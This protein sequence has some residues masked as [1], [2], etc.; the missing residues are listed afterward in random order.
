MED[1][2]AA[3]L[4]EKTLSVTTSLCATCK[5]T[6]PAEV[7]RVGEQVFLRKTCATHGLENALIST[8]AD[9]YETTV[10]HSMVLT[11]PAKS[12]PVQAGCPYDCGPCDAHEQR[13]HLPVVPITSKCDLDCPICYTH[14]KNEGAYHMSEDEISSILRHLQHAVPDRRILNLTGGEPTQHP[15]FERIVE[16]CAQFGI[17]R[18]TISTHGLRFL[19]DEPLLERLAKMGARIIL[20]FDSFEGE[21]NKKMLGGH[22]LNAKLRILDLLEKHRVD[23][24]LLPVLA[25]GVNDH[26]VGAFIDLALSKDF[27]R[28][29]EFHPMTFTG[30]SGTSFERSARYT[31][32]DA[33]ADIERQTQGRIRITDFVPSPLAHPLCYQIAYLLRLRDGRWIPFT[34]F[35]TRD[36]LRNLLSLALYIVP[37]PEMEQILADVLNRL[38]AGEVDC[39]DVDEVLASLKD[40]VSRM[41]AQDADEQRRMLIAETCTK[42]IYVHTHMDEETFDSDRIRK[43]CV[44]MPGPDGSNIPS[45]AYNVLYRERDARFTPQPAVPLV[46]LGRGRRT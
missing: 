17:N 4:V 16:L 26:E 46:Q 32:F 40:L 28:S 2:A 21:A 5:V 38:W 7:V 34:R 9:W 30:Q 35:M 36:D 22:H 12:R 20:S 18:V 19:R 45:C 37:G 10:A 27:I 39:D 25:R 42:A 31:A 44:G 23:T 15:A 8:S 24:T 43:C 3:G 1:G 33:V 6:V 41:F 13:N 29:V 11:P 14:N